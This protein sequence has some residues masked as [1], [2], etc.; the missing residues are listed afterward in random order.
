MQLGSS[1]GD[2]SS[3]QS[4]PVSSV[5]VGTGDLQVSVSWNT[6]A[7]LDLYLQ[8]PGG[9]LIYF[10]NPT[11]EAGG[12]LD[13]DSNVG[14]PTDDPQNE[15]ITYENATPPAGEY[16]VSLDLFSTCGLVTIPTDYVVTVRIGDIVE[17][18][19]GS[20]LP[21]ASSSDVVIT[22]FEIQ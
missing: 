3:S 19:T 14:C 21:D 2:V 17:T 20:L 15:N 9:E 11:S 4:L 1:A 16:I 13:L 7:D 6:R 22:T 12:V 18:H 8:E 5:V 10:V